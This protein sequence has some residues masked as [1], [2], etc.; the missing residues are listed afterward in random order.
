MGG[1]STS[2]KK[3]KKLFNLLSLV[4]SQKFRKGNLF[5]L[6]LFVLRQGSLPFFREENFDKPYPFLESQKMGDILAYKK[7]VRLISSLK[8]WSHKEYIIN[9]E[10]YL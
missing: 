10:V 4:E 8:R 2:E 6:D 7:F 1:G 9:D 5:Y 3:K